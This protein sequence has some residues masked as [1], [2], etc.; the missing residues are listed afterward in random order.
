MD[1]IKATFRT[2]ARHV[3]VDC[4]MRVVDI[5]SELNSC[6][7]CQPTAEYFDFVKT[8][9]TC[10]RVSKLNCLIEI[11]CSICFDDFELANVCFRI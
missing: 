10:L 11:K 2:G 1:Y 8:L 7:T 4:A 6:V 9:L 3:G 5:N